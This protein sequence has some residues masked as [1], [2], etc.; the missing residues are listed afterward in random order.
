MGNGVS[1][2]VAA[3]I[4][5]PRNVSGHG[6]LGYTEVMQADQAN[7]EYFFRLLYNLFFGSHGGIDFSST[8]AYIAH[9]WVWI[10]YA[11]YA[12][13]ALALGII[14]Y[15]TIRMFDLR[16]REEHHFGTVRIAPNAGSAEHTRW[17]HIKELVS[18]TSE[19]EWREAIIEA[20]IMLHDVLTHHG[21]VG[22]TVA[23]KLRSINQAGLGA[24]QDAWEA[25]KVR[26][27]IAHEGS[28]F[29]LSQSLAQRTIQRY[30]A[31]FREFEVI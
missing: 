13:S 29:P 4:F 2:G 24:L 17:D 18:G 20:D 15:L 9:L 7:V 21:Y 8:S 28:A 10:S 14:V 23:E 25:H 26:N 30:E 31:V 6:I 11:G 19:S 22:E 5:S 12:L 1:S 16:E 27:Q 3:L